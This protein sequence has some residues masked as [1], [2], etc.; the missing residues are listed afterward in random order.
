[1][2][3]C[4]IQIKIW[5]DLILLSNQSTN[6]SVTQCKKIRL[7]FV[8]SRKFASAGFRGRISRK[9]LKID[10]RSALRG[11]IS[12][13]HGESTGH[14]FNDV[15]WRWKPVKI[16]TAICLGAH[17]FKNDWRIQTRVG[18]IGNGTWGRYRMVTWQLTSRVP[19]KSYIFAWKYLEEHCTDSV[20][21]L[22]HNERLL[23]PAVAGTVA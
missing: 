4:L 5:F 3:F 22:L 2:G 12:K 13:W 18:P 16:V 15:T 10:R 21:L 7:Q 11:S 14:V 17:Y 19:E 6:R 1:M 23:S 8:A 20:L 9:R